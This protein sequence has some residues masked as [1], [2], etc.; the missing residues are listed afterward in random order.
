[1]SKKV[2]KQQTAHTINLAVQYSRKGKGSLSLLVVM[3]SYIVMIF[4]HN[5]IT[6]HI[7]DALA[8]FHWLPAPERIKFKL[9]VLVYRA[10]HGTAPRYLSGQLQYVADLPSRRRGRLRSSTSST[11]VRRDLLLSAIVRLL[12]PA[13]DAG[14]VYLSTSS[15]PRHSQHFVRK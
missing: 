4:K 11:S 2:L 8:S 14:T 15:V 12:L 7:T 10:L 6:E 1:M 3:R 13:R 5:K 9:A